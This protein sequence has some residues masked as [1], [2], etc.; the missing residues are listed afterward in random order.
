MEKILQQ[1]REIQSKNS[2]SKENK[3]KIKLWSKEFL[4]EE[5]KERKNCTNCWQDQVTILILKLKNKVKEK[6]GGYIC[7]YRLKEN[8]R[9]F[10]WNGI[11]FSRFTL[12]NEKA[13]M[14]AKY[15]SVAFKKFIEEINP[16]KETNVKE[17]NI[18]FIKE[19]Q[20][21]KKENGEDTPFETLI[22]Q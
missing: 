9:D 11:E 4:D 20:K 2:F 8:V 13:E 10:K 7:K 3:E 17:K 15:N 12:T 19:I 14:L 21:Q 6:N 18:N 16:A 22:N 5:F 1:L